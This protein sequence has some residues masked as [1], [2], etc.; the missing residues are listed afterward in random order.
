MARLP[1]VTRGPWNM[2]GICHPKIDACP[3]DGIWR[4]W[5]PGL[6]TYRTVE[7]YEEDVD[8]ILMHR[9]CDVL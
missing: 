8:D 5:C 3:G 2:F 4:N 6:E 7:V 9:K 1:E